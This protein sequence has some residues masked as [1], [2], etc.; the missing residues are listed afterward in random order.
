MATAPSARP[1]QTLRVHGIT[2]L[3]LKNKQPP[4]KSSPPPKPQ[5]EQA[6]PSAEK[7]N[8]EKPNVQKAPVVVPNLSKL[9]AGTGEK[10]AS[11]FVQD[12]KRIWASLRDKFGRKKGTS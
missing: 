9:V 4:A 2:K 7:P 12:Y 5:A 3:L 6:K 10:I 11:Y 1:V 8:P